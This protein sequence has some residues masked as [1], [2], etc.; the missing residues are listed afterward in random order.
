MTQFTM[1]A[2]LGAPSRAT[3]TRGKRGACAPNGPCGHG[4]I[5]T[6]VPG[7]KLYFGC[8]SAGRIPTYAAS[9]KFQTPK[10]E[11]GSDSLHS[12]NRFAT[13][14]SAAEDIADVALVYDAALGCWKARFEP[15]AVNDPLLSIGN[16]SFIGM[17]IESTNPQEAVIGSL[18]IEVYSGRTSGAA[19]APVLRNRIETT[20]YSR[21]M[22]T[23]FD[24]FFPLLKQAN[25]TQRVL[26]HEQGFSFTDPGGGAAIEKD[27]LELRVFGLANNAAYVGHILL[28]SRNA[29]VAVAYGRRIGV[30]SM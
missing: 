3:S 10:W 17:H 4:G 19:P 28:P 25:N 16:H 29:P 9:C 14:L 20:I 27:G 11:Q 21:P 23:V 2:L 7:N 22:A 24:A 18:T 26:L 30:A 5:A 8:A 15:G 1:G 6:S 13:N 12:R